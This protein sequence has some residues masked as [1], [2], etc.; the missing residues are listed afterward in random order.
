MPLRFLGESAAAVD[1]SRRRIFRDRRARIAG[2]LASAIEDG[3]RRGEARPVDSGRIA[4]LIIGM[5]WAGTAAIKAS[6]GEIAGEIAG[7]VLQG[8][9]EPEVA[10]ASPEARRPAQLGSTR[11]SGDPGLLPSRHDTRPDRV[12]PREATFR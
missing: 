1:Q 3:I 12:R 10:A 4:H 7:L 5:I 8:V 2:F 6:D 11:P 9:V